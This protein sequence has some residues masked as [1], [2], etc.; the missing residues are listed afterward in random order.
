MP[1]TSENVAE[2]YNVS[3]EDMDAFSAL[4]F[5]R[6]EHAQKSGYFSNEIVPF[7]VFVND[8]DPVTGTTTRRRVTATKDDGIRYGTTKE[9][10]LKISPAFPQWGQGRTTG[11]NASQVTDGVAAVVLMTRRKAEALGLDILGKYI[12]MA[13]TG[14]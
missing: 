6:A 3:R 7:N 14:M 12:S 1:W 13:V 2:D 10:L 11:G 5:Q 8:T 4:S 9:G